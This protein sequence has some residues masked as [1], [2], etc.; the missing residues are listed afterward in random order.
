MIEKIDIKT[1]YTKKVKLKNEIYY[2]L[3]ILEQKFA[4]DKEREPL[5][6][7]KESMKLVENLYLY[8]LEVYKYNR[9]L[10]HEGNYEEY[11][12]EIV[13]TGLSC[14]KNYKKDNEKRASFLT[15]FLDSWEKECRKSNFDN[16]IA[17]EKGF[18]ISSR[19]KRYVLSLKKLL[20]SKGECLS[21]TL[22]SDMVAE[23]L[24]I[25]IETARDIIKYCNLSN[26][27]VLVD[28]SGKEVNAIELVPDKSVSI[29]N[30]IIEHDKWDELMDGIDKAIG[31]LAQI[32][33]PYALDVLSCDIAS[34]LIDMNEEYS[35][36]YE[37]VNKELVKE[38]M[39]HDTIPKGKDIAAG[40][41]ISPQALSMAYS[42]L[43]KKIQQAISHKYMNEA[44]IQ[45]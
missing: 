1:E 24:G 6:H 19:Q 32:P 27:S 16:T 45:R 9:T 35:Y 8:V 12:Y 3:E 33:K 37:F 42:R 4:I 25:P 7:R 28:E 17:N 30:I 38:I 40:Y 36:D 41:D 26:S 15:Y 29:E 44:Q 21:M 34:V 43:V 5:K 39:T 13:K 22:H 20:N 23:H 2:W 10:L 11:G 18:S 31:K 14:I